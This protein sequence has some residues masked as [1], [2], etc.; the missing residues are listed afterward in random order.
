MENDRGRIFYRVT[1]DDLYSR[2]ALIEKARSL[3]EQHEAEKKFAVNFYYKKY[4]D[5]TS[6]I[7]GVVYLEECDHCEYKDKEGESVDFPF[8]HLEK[9]AADALRSLKF[10]TIGY[11][12]E[13][14]F[15]GSATPVR[16]I[17]LS[18]N[19]NKALLIY[20]STTGHSGHALVKKVVNGEERFYEPDDDDGEFY[21]RI[22][23]DQGFID[24][25]K[26]ETLNMQYIIED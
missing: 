2:E 20:Q 26:D 22:D 3:R 10:D 5:K 14:T 8:Y 9:P 18:S 24:F 19:T 7:A 1:I 25:Y 11:K 17:I 23:K 12:Q 15:L 16:N 13:A 4:T 21:Y 6:P